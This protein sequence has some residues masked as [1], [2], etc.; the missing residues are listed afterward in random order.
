[1]A[2]GPYCK[3]LGIDEEVLNGQ[4]I[5]VCE[6]KSISNGI[7]WELKKYKTNKK[8]T[9]KDLIEWLIKIFQVKCENSEELQEKLDKKFET[10]VGFRSTITRAPHKYRGELERLMNSAFD[11]PEEMGMDPVPPFEPT[12]CANL[13]P[14]LLKVLKEKGGDDDDSVDMS[15]HSDDDDEQ[16][17]KRKAREEIIQL[18]K[19]LGT[20]RKVIISLNDKLNDLNKRCQILNDLSKTSVSERRR[21]E[22]DIAKLKNEWNAIMV[23]WH[24]LMERLNHVNNNKGNYL[25]VGYMVRRNKTKQ[26]IFDELSFEFEKTLEDFKY[27]LTYMIEKERRK[28]KVV[29]REY[30]QKSTK[31]RKRARQESDDGAEDAKKPCLSE[32]AL[33]QPAPPAATSI[34][35]DEFLKSEKVDEFKAGK[36]VN[37]LKAIYIELTSMPFPCND[38]HEIIYSILDELEPLNT[39]KIPTQSFAGNIYMEAHMAVSLQAFSDLLN[40]NKISICNDGVT[41]FSLQDAT[42]DVT[43]ANETN[44]K[45]GVKDISKGSPDTSLCLLKDLFSEI[46]N[47]KVDGSQAA[48]AFLKKAKTLIP[49]YD[50]FDKKIIEILFLYK[51]QLSPLIPSDLDSL[52]DVFQNKVYLFNNFCTGLYFLLGL[53]KLTDFTVLAWESM[54]FGPSAG[55][56]ENGLRTSKTVQQIY[57]FCN[58][59]NPESTEKISIEFREFLQKTKKLDSQ[60]LAPCKGNLFNVI[61]HNSAGI[62]FYHETNI[63]TEFFEAMK[64]KEVSVDDLSNLLNEKHSYPFAKA[65][66]LLGKL[67]AVPLWTVLEDDD[68]KIGLRYN[69]LL[70]KVESW[71]KDASK[72]MRGQERLFDDVPVSHDAVYVSLIKDNEAS[73]ALTKELLEL[74][75]TAFVPY[76]K[77]FLSGPAA[78]ENSGENSMEVDSDGKKTI[79]ED[80]GA[81]DRITINMHSVATYAQDALVLYSKTRNGEWQDKLCNK[82]NLKVF[83]FV[84]KN[85][86]DHLKTL[87]QRKI[88]LDGKLNT[89]ELDQN[90]KWKLI[91]KKYKLI[92]DVMKWG[93][94]WKN[95]KE[96]EAQIKE[97]KESDMLNALRAQIRF[98][99]HVLGEEH[100]NN[101]LDLASEGECFTAA[102]LCEHLKTILKK[103]CQLTERNLE[104]A[105]ATDDKEIKEQV[106][107]LCDNAPELKQVTEPGKSCVP[108]ENFHWLLG[109]LVKHTFAA[110]QEK[111]TCT[112][113]CFARKNDACGE[114]SYFIRY[115]EKGVFR[116]PDARIAEDLK[117]QSLKV[118]D[119]SVND[120]VGSRLSRAFIK[121]D[122]DLEWL[123]C[124]VVGV[125]NR[126]SDFVVEFD[127]YGAHMPIT[128]WNAVPELETFTFATRLLEEYRTGHLRLL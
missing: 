125:T 122:G 56:W 80:F 6:A 5:K 72:F 105:T 18:K 47:C 86:N 66:G 53:A 84:E 24:D 57:S 37:A 30:R 99:R 25:D 31:D 12:V 2:L 4:K 108:K 51:Q 15:G 58:I 110:E 102:K 120:L 81:F 20:A 113:V 70:K 65:L 41:K 10:L 9:T 103:E 74:L 107:K 45:L 62:W 96:M 88:V 21:I 49:E 8:L 33:K 118:I 13:G 76:I 39:D 100:E 55:N 78:L 104:L 121:D 119:P 95:E 11:F 63:L 93:G 7:M 40:M 23:T 112:G 64:Q 14:K 16:A 91:E 48:E 116:V 32:E 128:E 42:Y 22:H 46:L 111:E 87:Y 69:S 3:A 82:E 97:M 50:F 79:H 90:S 43:L 83:E 98:R 44:L 28:K 126:G 61:F 34:S 85:C 68:V 92:D 75:F 1:M 101:L 123:D 35:V 124:K 71:S 19:D 27:K 106:T 60:P 54:S 73:D 59:V 77:Y 38:V 117:N 67:V 29:S 114:C 36:F 52:S 17:K 109:K 26:G 127:F 115:K 94:L 89:G